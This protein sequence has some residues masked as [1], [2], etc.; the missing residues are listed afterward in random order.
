MR[1]ITWLGKAQ[2][3]LQEVPQPQVSDRCTKVKIAYGGICGGDVGIYQGLH[4]RAQAPLIMGHETS[5]I[6]AEG[7]PTLAPGTPVVINPT[8]SCGECYPCTTG[9]KHVCEHLKLYGIDANGAMA[10][11]LTVPHS[12]IIPVPDGLSLR[13]A[14]LAEIVA[15][16]VHAIRESGYVAGDN[17]VVMGAGPIGLA[18]ALAL[19]N[20][21]CASPVVVEVNDTRRAMAVQLGFETIDPKAQDV[22]A[23][24]KAKTNGVGAD[25]VFDC[26]GHQA[27]AEMLPALVR[28]KGTIMVVAMYKTPPT[29]DLRMGMFKEF[30]V[31]F[32]RVYKEPSFAIALD[33]L[34]REPDFAQII[35]HVLNPQ[36]AEKG[37][38]LMLD[39][40]TTALKVLYDF[41]DEE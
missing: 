14:A 40:N 32:C 35:T 36:Q 13:T 41:T 16:V 34:Q 33:L 18:L 5:G 31:K 39:P 17:A 6:I 26:A 3:A 2:V 12:A 22:V 29:F 38:D 15:V 25:F 8:I 9:N 37:F 27:V 20:F 1:A 11:Y 28:I 4:P 21:G 19:R 30:Q 23:L 10:D 24:I 7:H